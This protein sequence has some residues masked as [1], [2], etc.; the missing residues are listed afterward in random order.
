MGDPTHKINDFL[1]ETTH[2]IGELD[3][4]ARDAA[5]RILLAYYRRGGGV[6]TLGNGGSAST[7]QHFAADLAKYVIPERARP[8][9][10]NLGAATLAL[11]GFDGGFLQRGSVCSVL[12]PAHYTR[13]TESSQLVVEH[14]LRYLLK[15]DLTADA[16]PPN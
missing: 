13:Q 11:V 4:R 6:F 12:V 1:N 8:F 10:N 7:A 5:R 2:L 14:L 15:E 3:R 16:H 9:A